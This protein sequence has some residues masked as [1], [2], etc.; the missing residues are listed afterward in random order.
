MLT[1]QWRSQDFAIGGGPPTTKQTNCVCVCVVRA[2]VCVSA[3]ACDIIMYIYSSMY[4]SKPTDKRHFYLNTDDEAL[5][6]NQ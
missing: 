5:A 4:I 1:E 2:W 3:R 6:F